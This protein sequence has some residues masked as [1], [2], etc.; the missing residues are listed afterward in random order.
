VR[1]V[2]VGAL[3]FSLALLAAAA[4]A[5]PRRPTTEELQRPSFETPVPDFGEP[6]GKYC[7]D[8]DMTGVGRDGRIFSSTVGGLQLLWVR[9][10]AQVVASQPAVSRGRVYVGD[11]SGTEYELNA[12]NGDIIAM[13]DL[14]RTVAS[15]CNPPVLGITSTPAISGDTIYLA[16]GDDAFY[17]LDHDTLAIRWR[18]SLGDNSATGGYYG[19]CSPSVVEGRVLQGVSSNCDNPF[20]PGQLV[21]LDSETGAISEQAFLVPSGQI[22]G[23][24]WTSPAVDLSARKVFVS[25]A[26]ALSLDEGLAYCVV[27]LS[28]DG[29]VIEDHWKVD[30]MGTPDADWGSSPTLFVDQAGRRLV[31]AGQKDGYYY[32]FLR[33]NL[34]QGPVWM[35][36]LARGGECPQCADGTLSTAAFDGSRLYVGAGGP[37]GTPILF[38]AGTVSALD[39]A[40]GAILWQYS[41]EGGPVIAPIT[42]VNDVV[43]VAGP[44]RIFALSAAAG[45]ELWSYPVAPCYGGIAISGGRILVGDTAGLFYAFGLPNDLPSARLGR[46]GRQRP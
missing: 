38:E 6:W 16:G 8:L 13:A 40:T 3:S 4:L 5:Q 15:Q 26:S 42:I 25:T 43:L 22:G 7:G 2:E 29:L 37:P 23:G 45:A 31:G 36:Q 10:L 44:S 20:V 46:E 21:A 30:P 39:P 41:V 1:G 27:R 35:T 17:A 32:A 11:W 18:T 9:P 19:W 28:L 12:E 34:A 33:D 14:G 24:V